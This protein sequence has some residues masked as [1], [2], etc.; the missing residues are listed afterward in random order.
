MEKAKEAVTA[1]IWLAGTFVLMSEAPTTIPGQVVNTLIAFL[2]WGLAYIVW[3]VWG[4]LAA[5][6]DRP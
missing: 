2:L 6:Q 5:K 3:T 1:L 4:R